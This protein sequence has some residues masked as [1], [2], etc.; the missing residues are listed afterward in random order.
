MAFRDGP[1]VNRPD[2]PPAVRT[3]LGKDGEPCL[4]GL[5]LDLIRPHSSNSGRRSNAAIPAKR[6]G[7]PAWR[8]A[9]V[10]GRMHSR[11]ADDPDMDELAKTAGLSR[12]Q[13]FRAFKQETRTTP[14]RY[15]EQ[16]RIK[17]AKRLLSNRSL[18]CALVAKMVG[19]GNRHRLCDAFRRCTRMTPAEYRA[20]LR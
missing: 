5:A 4:T 18:D 20:T 17:Q 6:G 2:R 8:L 19:L 11:L 9:R 7:L 15:L 10:I 12:A 1:I 14:A 13:F 3:Q 16:I